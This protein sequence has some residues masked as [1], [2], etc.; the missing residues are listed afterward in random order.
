MAGLWG[1]QSVFDSYLI[2]L[3]GYFVARQLIQ[4]R[5]AFDRFSHTLLALAIILAALTISEQL[6]G[7]SPFR[8]QSTSTYYTAGVRKVAVLLGNP[9]YIAVTL[10]TILPLALIRLRTAT[11]HRWRLCLRRG[12]PAYG[13]GDLLHLQPLG[14]DRGPVGHI[15]GAGALRLSSAGLRC[16]PLSSLPSLLCSA[17]A[18]CKTRPQASALPPR[19]L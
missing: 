8:V 7:F 15:G 10:A 1:V 14:L 4:T 16:P 18:P 6:T 9:A 17:G 2:P 11:S 12:V 5:R 19:A 13:N 3:L